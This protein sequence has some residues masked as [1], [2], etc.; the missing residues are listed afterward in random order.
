YLASAYP[1]SPQAVNIYFCYTYPGG[2]PQ[3]GT[4]TSAPTD[5]SWR[6]GDIN[7]SLLM[8]FQLITPFIQSLFGN[9]INVAY[10]EHFTIQGKP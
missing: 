4:M 8:N 9:G 5:N 7:V 10:N 6:L 2:A 3:T 1:S